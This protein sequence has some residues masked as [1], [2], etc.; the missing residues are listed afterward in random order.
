MTPSFDVIVIGGG[1]IGLA[2]AIMMRQQGFK[3]A[4]VDA[5]SMAVDLST[6][7]LRVYAI[8]SVSQQVLMTLGVWDHLDKTRLSPY[9]HMHV[10]DAA[11]K[12]SIDF[13]ARM[14]GAARLGT[15]IEESVLKQALLQGLAEHDIHVYPNHSLSSV[16]ETNDGIT[17]QAQGQLLSAQLLMV[18]DGAQSKTR[19][20]LGVS[21]TTWPYH[22]HALVANVETTL[23]HQGTAYQVFNADG[24]LAFLPLANPHHSSIVWSTT[25]THAQYLCGLSQDDFNLELTSAFAEKLGAVRALS[26]LNTFPLHMR[27]VTQ[28]SGDHWML[29]GDAAHTIHPLAGLGL[30]IGLE[31]LSHFRRLLQASKHKPWSNKILAQYHRQRK[32]DVWKTIA[33]M[34]GLK[35]LFSNPLYPVVALRG[36]G[37]NA[38]DK[39]AWLKRWFIEQ[40]NGA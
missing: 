3:V 5:G 22:H 6:P 37:L 4:V 2:A 36:F 11:S 35:S 16:Q 25:P 33:V 23:P 38:C 31:D 14:I 26:A 39:T 30:N 34:Q 29:L 13:D 24:P 10:W 9:Q 28:Y 1:V 20:L 17:I 21:L 15:F 8:N 27:H 32:S 18:A 40:A 19:D 7:D 12:A